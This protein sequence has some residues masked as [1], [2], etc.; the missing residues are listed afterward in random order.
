MNKQPLDE[1]YT[2]E[3]AAEKLGYSPQNIRLL[4]S[5]NRL[6]VVRFHRKQFLILRDSVDTFKRPRMGRPFKNKQN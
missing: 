3:Q 6:A 1:F 2:C 5:Q 4:V